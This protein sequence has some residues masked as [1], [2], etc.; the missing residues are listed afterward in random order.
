MD[1]AATVFLLTFVAFILLCILQGLKPD[2]HK[3]EPPV[4]RIVTHGHIRVN[5]V[6]LAYRP[7]AQ[8]RDVAPDDFYQGCY[9]SLIKSVEEAKDNL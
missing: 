2:R 1:T 7:P 5:V 9:E 6:P 3:P 8:P 4:V